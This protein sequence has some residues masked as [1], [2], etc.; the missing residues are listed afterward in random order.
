MEDKKINQKKAAELLTLSTRT[1][2]RDFES[3]RG[4]DNNYSGRGLFRQIQI[5]FKNKKNE[6]EKAHRYLIKNYQD[7]GAFVGIFP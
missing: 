4:T 7:A 6:H 1:I 3:Q 5:N 2:Q